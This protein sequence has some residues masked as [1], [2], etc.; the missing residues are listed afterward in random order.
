[1]VQR[2]GRHLRTGGEDAEGNCQIKAPSVLGQVRGGKVEG[3]ASG[4]KVEGRIEDRAANPVL[5][6]LHG[7][8]G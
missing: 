3:D 2:Q 6:F 5:A 4:W 7:G 1:M 8:F